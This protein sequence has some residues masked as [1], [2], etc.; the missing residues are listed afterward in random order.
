MLSE[1]LYAVCIT[2][3]CVLLGTMSAETTTLSLN[4]REG[5]TNYLL[6]CYNHGSASDVQKRI[7]WFYTKNEIRE[8]QIPTSLSDPGNVTLLASWSGSDT[9][10]SDSKAWSM[11]DYQ[12][13]GKYSL[14]IFNASFPRDNGYFYCVDQVSRDI[15][16]RFHLQ[17]LVKITEIWI[18]EAGDVEGT[19]TVDVTAG[20]MARLS[21]RVNRANPAP[22]F[23][24]TKNNH[25]FSN[26]SYPD[27]GDA[28]S[29]VI[30]FLPTREMNGEIVRCLANN[31]N[32]PDEI[33]A[34]KLNVLYPPVVTVNWQ[35]GINVLTCEAEGN[36]AQ[37]EFYSWEHRVRSTLV[38]TMQ[39][40]ASES[41]SVLHLPPSGYF[42]TGDYIC[43][44]SNGVGHKQ[45]ASLLCAT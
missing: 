32:G 34:A 38:D 30:T 17:I 45:S 25:L 18:T 2:A 41:T 19:Q 33:A 10:V 39:G 5:L 1:G 22:D 24:W 29:G 31:Q 37:Y 11:D 36:P 13:G 14:R 27:S 7:S 21:C 43:S 12:I 16:R 3:L 40:S 15:I 35:S 28:N 8:S 44:V 26:A 42:V 4:V 23:L 9:Y 6:H 20:E